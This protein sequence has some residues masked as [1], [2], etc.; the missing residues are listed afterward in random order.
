MVTLESLGWNAR[1]AEEFEKFKDKDWQPARLIRDNKISY[2]AL[3]G[4]GTEMEV[5]MSGAVYHEAATDA[6][7]PA[8][9]DWVALGMG[10]ENDEYEAVI[11]A[12]LERQTCLSRKAPGKGTEEQ[13]I[14]ANVDVVFVITDAGQ[15]FNPRRMERYYA[16]MQRSGARSVAILNKSDV[17]PEEMN[18][19]AAD[20]L[21]SL[22]PD[23]EVIQTCAVQRGGV[24]AIR[25]FIEPGV[26]VAMIGSS[27][28]GK[29]SLINHL[30][31]EAVQWMGEVNAV[32]GKGMHTTTAR[33]LLVLPEGGMLIDN[34][35]IREVQM[36]T[37][38]KTLKESFADFDLLA[39]Q[40]KFNDCKHGTDKGCAIRAAIESGELSK[41]RFINYL[42]L[43]FELE[44]LQ[45][46]QKKRQITIGRRNR[47][48]LKSKA[49]KYN[50]HKGY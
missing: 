44:R 29:S 16:V 25:R 30:V 26:T 32:T 7:L 39:D 36:W 33:E 27:G 37:D 31:G 23:I 38:A 35:G 12:R 5:I 49:E 3:L 1:Y 45:R 2:G 47:R 22:N 41:E 15:D 9:G 10:E 17:Y 48:E 46:R 40:C 6:D 43:D 42:K 28:V 19:L 14:A 50:K 4:D 11:R 18:Q 34:P 21:R 13:V 24:E 8:V 20:G